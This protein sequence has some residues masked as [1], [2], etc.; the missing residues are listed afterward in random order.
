MIMQNSSSIGTLWS[1]RSLFVILLAVALSITVLG[2]EQTT[3]P[4]K[5]PTNA[6]AA[7]SAPTTSPSGTYADDAGP[8]TAQDVINRLIGQKRDN[9]VIEATLSMPKDLASTSLAAPRIL[10]TAPG[11]KPPTLHREGEFIVNRRGHIVRAP[12]GTNS[13]FVFE[14][15]SEKA[16]EPPMILIPC[17]RRQDMEDY[18]AKRGN[19]VVFVVSGQ[20]FVYR[21]LNYLLPN[22]FKLA[23]N[24]GNLQ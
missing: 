7:T 20:V 8:T 15:D 4:T 12:D 22:M 1:L 6:P 11:T 17:A 10:G 24:N 13:M 2:Q 23:L 21:G 14:A 5:S 16:P 18:V 19:K 3:S 9:S